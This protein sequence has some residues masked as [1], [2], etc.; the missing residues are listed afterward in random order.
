MCQQP[1]QLL[2][3]LLWLL[4]GSCFSRQESEGR[5]DYRVKLPGLALVAGNCWCYA[6]GMFQGVP[7]AL[8]SIPASRGTSSAALL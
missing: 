6:L 7:H 8:R 2:L 3:L 4:Q 1:W 5:R